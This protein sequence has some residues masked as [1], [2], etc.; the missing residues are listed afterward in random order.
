MFGSPE[1]V[2][3]E[4]NARLFIADDFGD[5]TATIRCKL[6]MGHG[7][8]HEERFMRDDNEVFITWPHDERHHCDKHGVQSGSYCRPC[9]DEE[10]AACECLEDG[11][12]CPVHGDD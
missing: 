10:D 4:C 1:D 5:N 7:G 11:V 3:G 12:T 8:G 6:P 2:P 9:M